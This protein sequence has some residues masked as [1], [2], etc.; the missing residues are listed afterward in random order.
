MEN[1]KDHVDGT[2]PGAAAAHHRRRGVARQHRRG[3][4]G[5]AK[6]HFR[7]FLAAQQ[8]RAC[9]EIPTALLVDADGDDFVFLLV[10]RLDDVAR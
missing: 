3:I 7:S 2:K 1:R 10:H 6:F 9:V 5:I 4:L 8:P